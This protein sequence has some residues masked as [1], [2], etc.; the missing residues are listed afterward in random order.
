MNRLSPEK[1]Q[2]IRVLVWAGASL[3]DIARSLGISKD[4]VH[5]YRSQFLSSTTEKRQCRHG[6][7]A[8]RCNSCFAGKWG[9][10]IDK[11]AVK[12]VDEDAM[13]LLFKE[14]LAT[15]FAMSRQ[16][17][18]RIKKVLPICRR[19]TMASLMSAW[20]QRYQS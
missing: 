8:Y 12:W 3:R 15:N 1:V 2:S 5:T 6:N 17:K 18:R 7:D 11:D 19:S 16:R 13:R 9:A 14:H 10:L 4:T 20:G